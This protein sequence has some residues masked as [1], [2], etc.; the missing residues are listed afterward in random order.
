[1]KLNIIGSGSGLIRKERSGPSFLVEE[2]EDKIILDCGWGCLEGLLRLGEDPNKINKMFV[3]HSHAD[4]MVELMAW[5]QSKV[6]FNCYNQDK[7]GKTRIWGYRGIKEDYQCL[8]TMMVPEQGDCLEVEIS[9]TGGETGGMKLIIKEVAHVPYLK[10]SALRI[11]SRGK[12]LV[13]SG[14]VHYHEELADLA[15]G[16]DVLLMDGSVTGKSF[17]QDG[18]GKTHTSP[19]EAGMIAAKA[20]V[21]KL[22][23][24]SI[25]DLEPVE[26][27]R[28]AAAEHYRGEI[29]IPTDLETIEF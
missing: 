28:K 4:H 26:E 1:M 7:I 27:S 16:A 13:Y 18:P 17:R 6:I 24:F 29:I 23:L 5:I 21:K 20:G 15:M 9:E 3:S 2:G 11:E 12:V 22:V 10:S 25:Y 8:M 19:Q 14:D